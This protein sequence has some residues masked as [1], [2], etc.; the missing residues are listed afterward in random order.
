MFGCY[1][2]FPCFFR[3]FIADNIHVGYDKNEGAMAGSFF[4]KGGSIYPFIGHGKMGDGVFFN[5]AAYDIS[6]SAALPEIH[7][8]QRPFAFRTF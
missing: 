4:G 1:F 8:I 6:R 2:R 7:V 3:L 5:E